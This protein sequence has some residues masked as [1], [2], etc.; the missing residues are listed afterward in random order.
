MIKVSGFS[1]TPIHR[2]IPQ[3]QKKGTGTLGNGPQQYIALQNGKDNNYD[4]D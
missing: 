3:V 4:R 1:F 2:F